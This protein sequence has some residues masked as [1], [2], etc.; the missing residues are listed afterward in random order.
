VGSSSLAVDCL[1]ALPWL[2]LA[3][4]ATATLQWFRVAEIHRISA[5]RSWTLTKGCLLYLLLGY[6]FFVLFQLGLFRPVQFASKFPYAS[7]TVA[8]ILAALYVISRV[9]TM[10]RP[11]KVEVDQ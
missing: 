2:F 1:A 5:A 7:R 4:V 8:I 11:L 9:A 10:A 3:G 6:A